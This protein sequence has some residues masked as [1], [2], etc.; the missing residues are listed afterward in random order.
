M[1]LINCVLAIVFAICISYCESHK[2]RYIIHHDLKKQYFSDE[3]YQAL[4]EQYN[5]QYEQWCS[6]DEEN[7]ANYIAKFSMVAISLVNFYKT[8]LM[9][10]KSQFVIAIISIVIPIILLLLIVYFIHKNNCTYIKCREKCQK[11]VPVEI[12]YLSI[13]KLFI[14]GIDKYSYIE[15]V[16]VDLTDIDEALL[17]LT[18]RICAIKRF[19]RLEHKYIMHWLMCTTIFATISF[20]YIYL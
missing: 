5:Q 7:D 19:Q 8:T 15:E 14:D 16:N 1:I 17:L 6:Y 4:L 9:L 10:D 13:F 12:S 2:I 20:I 11:D 3:R 18:K